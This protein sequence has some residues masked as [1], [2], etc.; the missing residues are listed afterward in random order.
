[1]ADWES[2][3]GRRAIGRAEV[4]RRSGRVGAL[5]LALLVAGLPAL[6]RPHGGPA[7][8]VGAAAVAVAAAQR[9]D[10][11][12]ADF[13]T[14]AEAQAELARDPSDP[15]RLDANGDGNRGQEGGNG[16]EAAT[17]GGGDGNGGRGGRPRGAARPTPAP[18]PSPTAART[19]G[20]DVDCVDLV[21]QEAAQELLE[22]DPTDPFNL[23][24]SGDGFA[25]SS[26]PSRARSNVVALPATGTGG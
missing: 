18:A 24:P 4:V 2:A 15:N 8:G 16:R 17:A 6:V 12:C 25:C 21:Y 9:D 10:L 11:N 19:G 26:L 7:T 23:D 22:R 14:Q 13:A 1:M 5:L 3:A 20:R